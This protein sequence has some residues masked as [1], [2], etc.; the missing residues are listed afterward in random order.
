MFQKNFLFLSSRI[1]F[2]TFLGVAEV[3]IGGLTLCLLLGDISKESTRIFKSDYRGE[4]A[5]A[6]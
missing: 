5:K 4:R 2:A 1:S 3:L 6:V